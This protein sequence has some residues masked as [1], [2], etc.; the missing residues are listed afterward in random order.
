MGRKESNQ[1]NK[2]KTPNQPWNGDLL[3]NKSLTDHVTMIYYSTQLLNWPWNSNL[4]LNKSLNL[5]MTM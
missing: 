3:L 1:T 2:N 4:F 5:K